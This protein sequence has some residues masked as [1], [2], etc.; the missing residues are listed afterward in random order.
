MEYNY[1]EENEVQKLGRNWE[2]GGGWWWWWDIEIKREWRMQIRESQPP[3]GNNEEDDCKL[4]DR[5]YF[6]QWRI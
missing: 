2:I 3:N 6:Y 4:N 5:D 1:G